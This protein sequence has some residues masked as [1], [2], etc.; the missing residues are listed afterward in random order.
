MAGPASSGGAA[1]RGEPAA[2]LLSVIG[3]PAVGKT[4]LAEAFAAEL[5][6]E[7]IYE[8]YAGNPFLAESYLGDGAARLPAQLYYLMSRVKQLALS[9]WPREGLR[10]SDYGFCQDRIYAEAQLTADAM[11]LYDRVA[12]RLEGLVKRPD[13]VVRLD[14]A[15]PTLLRR[16]AE[17]G[18][19]F[20][21]AM[22]HKFLSRLRA[23]YSALDAGGEGVCVD[24]DAV[25]LRP[26]E[27]L[28]ALVAE[29][30]GRL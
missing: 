28:A 16:I 20:E 17:R 26:G 7:V 8:D 27:A 12:R 18:R 19:T 23:A 21:Q 22:T 24:C 9:S 11:R 2:K 13:L 3:P 1:A 25:D 14:A 5:G 4:T 30:R 6:G 29:V 15:E 10:V